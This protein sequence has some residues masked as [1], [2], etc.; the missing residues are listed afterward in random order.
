MSKPTFSFEF[1]P[2][3]T[4][5]AADALWD[6]VPELM[7]LDPKFMTVTYGAGGTTKD[8][9]IDTIQKKMDMTDIPI[10]S[11][12]TFLNTTKQDLHDYV[13]AP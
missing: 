6:A 4:D 1:F 12:L 5:K 13:D 11:H 9:T 2:P 8:G 3:K 7:N 10:G